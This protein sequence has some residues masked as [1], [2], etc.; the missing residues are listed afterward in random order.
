MNQ[1]PEIPLGHYCY[2]IES[3]EYGEKDEKSAQMANL[4]GIEDKGTVR[5]KTKPCPYWGR[6][7]SKGE[8]GYGNG[9]CTLTGK[10]D[11]VDETLLWDQVKE[12]GINEG[13]ADEDEG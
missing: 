13:E 8:D 4:F 5:I 10:K 3:I 2:T 12:C 11:W 7:L 9:F 6:D 1:H